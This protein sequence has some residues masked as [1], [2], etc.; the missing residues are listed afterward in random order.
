MCCYE[1]TYDKR[2]GGG[3]NCTRSSSDESCFSQTVCEN[4]PLGLS[5]EYWDN[6]PLHELVASW[7]RLTPDARGAIIQLVRESG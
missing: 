2:N 7:H 6:A 4:C 3:G 1:T 5:E